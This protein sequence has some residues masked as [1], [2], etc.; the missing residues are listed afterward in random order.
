MPCTCCRNGITVN[1]WPH[2]YAPEFNSL[3]DPPLPPALRPEVIGR[4]RFGRIS[5]ANADSGAAA[6]TDAAIDQA[7]RAVHELLSAEVPAAAAAL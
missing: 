2:G 3:F 5:I 1:R 7:Y 6:Y 4:A